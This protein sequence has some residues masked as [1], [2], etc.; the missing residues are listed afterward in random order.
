MM[1]VFLF[2]LYFFV[3]CLIITR[4]G[5]FR[6]YIRPVYLILLFSLHVATGCLHNWIAFHYYPGH[7]DIWVFFEEG[8]R[9]RKL[10]VYDPASFFTFL[11][12]TGFNITDTHKPLLDFQYQFF[13]RVNVL[14]NIF[15]FDNI[16]INTLLF[17]L[18]VFAGTMALFKFFYKIYQKP[19]PAFCSL[20]LP[21]V[22]F[23]T[24]V[25][26][27]DGV[28]YM[29]IGYFFYFLLFRG[30]PTPQRIILLLVCTFLMFISRANAL[31][32]LFPALLFFFLAEKLVTKKRAFVF[33]MLA[34]L[35]VVI[36]LNNLLASGILTVVSERQKDFQ[37]LEGGSRIA[38]PVLEPSIQSALHILPTAF[39]NGFFQ[40]FPGVGGKS[41]YLAFSVELMV[42]WALILLAGWLLV[43]RK[44]L[45]LSNFDATCL[46]FAIPGM[47][48]IGYMVPF[49]GAIIRYRSIYLPFLLA[50][51]VNLLCSYPV[52][53]AT[54]IDNWLGR[55]IIIVSGK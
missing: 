23:W 37:S 44:T 38:L 40:P 41:I 26:Y 35:M 21:S 43:R 7:G 11:D 16:Y 50:P 54:R 12:S 42:Y 28:F 2:I 24:S 20:L 33:T 5:F 1:H 9:L 3:L 36:L 49:A 47:I 30:K 32:T 6:G 51:F 53:I 15:S 29:A 10:F 17:S 48:I 34:A 4:L 18:P 25:V 27:K 55:N 22:L 8:I 19:L 39:A 13:Q 52:A 14:L 46:L 45:R 31:I